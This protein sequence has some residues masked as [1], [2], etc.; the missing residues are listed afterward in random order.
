MANKDPIPQP[1]LLSNEKLI[2]IIGDKSVSVSVTTFRVIEI[3]RE[4]ESTTQKILQLDEID[5]VETRRTQ[6]KSL[7]VVAA[8][9]MLFGCGLAVYLST[10]EAVYGKPDNTRFNETLG[11]WIAGG[12]VFVSAACVG[13]FFLTRL[14]VLKINSKTNA[15]TYP[16]GIGGLKSLH[17]F[18]QS[19][20]SAIQQAKIIQ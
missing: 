7:I 1:D 4:W 10:Q 11:A 9:L 20:Q 12:S 13:L 18:V 19:V 14:Y 6:L 17:R 8:L 16:C 2:D 5:S 15:I 3:R